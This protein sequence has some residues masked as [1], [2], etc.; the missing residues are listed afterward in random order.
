MEPQVKEV[1]L[2]IDNQEVKAKEGATILDAAKSL[3]I[4]IPT[5]CYLK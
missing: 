4:T 5:L 1:T 3:G 2:K